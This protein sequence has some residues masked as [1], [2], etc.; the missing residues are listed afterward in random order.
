MTTTL[1]PVTGRI[2]GQNQDEGTHKRYPVTSPVTPGLGTGL[3]ATLGS[4]GKV[5]KEAE[6][7][8]KSV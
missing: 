2:D 5:E 4:P 8:R 6:I 3:A 7:P 1:T